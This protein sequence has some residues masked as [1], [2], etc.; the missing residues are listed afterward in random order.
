MGDYGCESLEYW[1]KERILAAIPRVFGR[2]VEARS[3]AL[4]DERLKTLLAWA[5]KQPLGLLT[6]ALLYSYYGDGK[7]RMAGTYF[8]DVISMENPELWERYHKEAY[9]QPNR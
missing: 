8:D 7:Y 5:E 9:A 1:T 3:N 2:W 6:D 4:F